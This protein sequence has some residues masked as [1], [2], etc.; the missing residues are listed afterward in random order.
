M[1]DGQA[2][3]LQSQ[4]EPWHR[5]RTIPFQFFLS[6]LKRVIGNPSFF[7]ALLLFGHS[8]MEGFE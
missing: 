1:D 5:R 3:S 4:Y 7:P 8:L 6:L 2:G